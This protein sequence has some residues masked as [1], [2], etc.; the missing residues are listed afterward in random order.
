MTSKIFDNRD[1]ELSFA[2]KNCNLIAFFEE[3]YVPEEDQ[4]IIKNKLQ[5]IKNIYVD[6][7]YVDCEGNKH[8]DAFLTEDGWNQLKDMLLKSNYGVNLSKNDSEG[9]VEI[10]IAI[11][12]AYVYEELSKTYSIDTLQHVQIAVK[13]KSKILVEVSQDFSNEWK[14][15]PGKWQTWDK[16]TFKKTSN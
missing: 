16:Y 7:S 11:I 13:D 9:L 6:K 15:Y 2:F 12:K 4:C 8:T 1:I 5:K 3:N 14:N 10:Y